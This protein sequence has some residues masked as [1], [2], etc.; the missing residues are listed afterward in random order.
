MNKYD[1]VS[2]VVRSEESYQQKQFGN[3]LPG[4]PSIMYTLQK[5]TLPEL[6]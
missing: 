6:Q 3:P 1:E 5:N 2:G 4:D